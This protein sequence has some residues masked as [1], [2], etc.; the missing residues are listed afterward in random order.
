MVESPTRHGLSQPLREGVYRWF[1]RWLMG[2]EE[3]EVSQ[4]IAV[5][6]RPD[7]ELLV[8]KAGQVNVSFQS[9]P[10][11]PLALEE[12]R[13]NKMPQNKSLREVL[14]L[15]IGQGDPLV[16]ELDGASGTGKPLVI[17]VNDNDAPDW[18]EA[19]SLLPSLRRAGYAV[20]IVDPRGVGRRR[21]NLSV[22][23][24]SY[25]NPIS[26][27]EA[28]IAYNAFL[29]GQSLLGLRVADVL[30]AVQSLR[31]VRKPSKLTLCGRHDAALVAC[32]AAAVDSS[33]DGVAA[34]ELLLSYLPLFSAEGFP[35]NAASVLPGLLRDFGD[36]PDVLRQI[37]PRRIL[38]AAGVGPFPQ[39]PPISA[40]ISKTPFSTNPSV[41]MDWLKS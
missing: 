4:E 5:Q 3:P 19:E 2:R 24:H 40:V 18:R 35:L 37:S 1:G 20:A 38:I 34:E 29:V 17:C 27:V 14:N 22:G 9:R 7:A 31:R 39:Q 15:N 11:L 30:A 32:L 16:N 36:I 21:A 12:S 6:P 28:N 10:L 23:G 33:I 25:T 8:C 41:L 26:S 13:K